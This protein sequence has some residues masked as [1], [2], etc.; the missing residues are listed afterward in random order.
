MY[1]NPDDLILFTY[2][3]KKKLA[4]DRCQ[5][6]RSPKSRK[7]AFHFPMAPNVAE[8]SH[9]LGRTLYN[10]T[11]IPYFY[12]EARGFELESAGQFFADVGCFA[13]V[14]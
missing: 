5:R 11:S 6:S 13:D 2:L 9:K 8:M 10:T 4:G 3:C 7:S 12:L 14:G 1:N